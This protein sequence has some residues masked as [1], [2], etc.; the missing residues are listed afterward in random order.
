MTLEEKRAIVYKIS[1][2]DSFL[3]APTSISLLHYLFEATQNKNDLKEMVIALEFFGTKDP[4]TRVRVNVYNLRKK[5][6]NYYEKEGANDACQLKIEKGQYKVTFEKNGTN[7]IIPLVKTRSKKIISLSAL[8]LIMGLVLFMKIKSP[9]SSIWKPFFSN[10]KKTN[11][12]VG[13]V[14]GVIGK[15]ITGNKGWTRDYSINT[16]EQF[17][18]FIDS[19]PTLKDSIAPP[20]YSYVNHTAVTG[21]VALANYFSSYDKGFNVRFSSKTSIE[22]I[23]AHNNIYIGSIKNENTFINLFNQANPYF[24]LK[25]SLLFFSNHPKLKDTVFKFPYRVDNEELAIVSKIKGYDATVQL[26]FFSN[27][28]I[29]INACVN[30]F[31]DKNKLS[32]FEKILGEGTYFT[33][34]FKVKGALRSDTNIELLKNISFD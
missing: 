17:Y 33:A 16:V 8:C 11:L 13:D 31:S 12:I 25:D 14:F 5:L 18:S 19:H 7:E 2:S 6:N 15:T 34:I 24:K 22:E 32:Q 23:K 26:L 29:G 27:H 30:Y 28:D 9:V 10:A 1:K 21:A 20:P 4:G 3:N